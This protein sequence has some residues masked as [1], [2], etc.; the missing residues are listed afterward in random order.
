VVTSRRSI[1]AVV[2]ALA[3]CGTNP[4][5]SG[6]REVCDN[7]RDDNADG[8][9]DCL[10]PTCFSNM[11]CSVALTEDCGNQTD[12]DGDGQVDCADS[13][14][15]GA[16]C[17]SGCLCL[18]GRPTTSM[19]GG[20]AG[21]G[22]SG[23]AAAGG[24]AGGSTA[25]GSAGG[26]TAGGSAGGSTA[27][28]SAGGST[29]GGSTAGG[30][31]GGSTAGGS[32]GGSTAGGSAGGAAA[33]EQNC[34]D[35][36]DNDG[37]NATDCDDGDC[38]GITCGMGCRCVPGRRTEVSCS[39]GQDNDGDTLTDCADSD[40]VGVGTEICNDGVDNT[41]DRA[42]D[43]GDSK[44]TN[45]PQC[46]NL[47]D[48]RP[49]LLPGQCAG[50]RCRTEAAT[51]VPNG[52]CTNALPCSVAN[53]TGCNGGRCVMS[54]GVASCL[55]P[56]SGLGTVGPTACR[57]GFFCVDADGVQSTADSTCR[58]ACANDQECSGS[59]P[60]Y[61]CNPWLKLCGSKDRGL[62]KYGAA[63]T[64]DSQCEGGTCLTDARFFPNGS[65]TGVCRRDTANCAPDGAC[66][67]EPNINDNFGLCYRRCTGPNGSAG[68]CRTAD[69]YK[70][71]P[72]FSGGPQACSCLG[73]GGPC[74]LGGASD[75][76]S[77]LCNGLGTCECRAG[78]SGCSANREC[79]SG[80]CASGTCT[81]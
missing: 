57:P 79:C 24:S 76:C 55:P 67:T 48:G 36:L 33:R 31:A 17:G 53:Q 40:C 3:A 27:G 69:N 10:D 18:N 81:F 21:G 16:A 61:G 44:C 64:Q 8:K 54:G 73:A 30:S 58:P 41:C 52:M 19:T 6:G 80:I 5:G 75:C 25:G 2:L 28:G 62:A 60:G 66:N 39:D 70:C 56:C 77:G 63:C 37:D 22:S 65:C 59:G 20:G 11:R 34:A 23:G 7:G 26:S 32:A 74:L 29:A 45:S 14:C 47:P 46:T 78:L 1:L 51:G 35:N 68:G 12:D 43:C 38:A 9:I 42:I 13:S 15:D 50:G 71:W 49:C 4:P 72:L